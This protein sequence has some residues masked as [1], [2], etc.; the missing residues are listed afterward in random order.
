MVFGD[1]LGSTSSSES[2]TIFRVGSIDKCKDMKSEEVMSQKDE[3]NSG[4]CKL[5]ESNDKLTEEAKQKT[6]DFDDLTL[7]QSSYTTESSKSFRGSENEDSTELNAETADQREP[8]D[9]HDNG[10]LS[11]EGTANEHTANVKNGKR[12]AYENKVNVKFFPNDGNEFMELDSCAATR[13]STTIN[14]KT[15]NK[16]VKRYI[17]LYQKGKWK[18][19]VA[20]ER[21]KMQEKA[22]KEQEM[23]RDHMKNWELQWRAK[24]YKLSQKPNPTAAQNRQDMLYALS[25]EKQTR[26]DEL[27][28]KAEQPELQLKARHL[29]RCE[30]PNPMAARDRQSML[31]A[32]SKDKQIEGKNRRDELKKKAQ[33]RLAKLQPK[34]KSQPLQYKQ[35]VSTPPSTVPSV[36][37][38]LYSLSRSEQIRGKCRRREIERQ[39]TPKVGRG[40]IFTTMER[41]NCFHT[42]YSIRGSKTM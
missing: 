27:K 10:T 31:F 32:L 40:T 13:G 33:Q 28:K 16:P 19:I 9:E 14:E 30:K 38:R 22:K 35:R 39:R 11:R 25:K 6:Q 1:L 7:I 15:H 24:H 37:N 2:S 8:R 5:K 21:E 42:S 17:R 12:I 26:L 29:K 36:V 34:T 4:D 41:T 20:R 18:I 23:A 3:L